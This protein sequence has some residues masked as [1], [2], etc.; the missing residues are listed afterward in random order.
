MCWSDVIV[1]ATAGEV[2]ES[3]CGRVSRFIRSTL[4]L[5][6]QRSEYSATIHTY[7]WV[8]YAGTVIWVSLLIKTR[9]ARLICLILQSNSWTSCSTSKACEASFAKA[10]QWLLLVASL[11]SPA[12][13]K[14]LSCYFGGM[15]VLV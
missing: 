2:Q 7:I 13:L 10:L 5:K 12:N 1:D 8:Y 9:M 3:N 15:A 6:A 14:L 11:M 4:E